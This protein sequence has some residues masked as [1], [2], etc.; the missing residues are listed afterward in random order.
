MILGST[1]T[2]GYTPRSLVFAVGTAC[3]MQYDVGVPWRVQFSSACRPC[4]NHHV[5]ETLD[6]KLRLQLP[7]LLHPQTESE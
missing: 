2:P 4:P 1:R 6:V 3:K 5:S 7:I